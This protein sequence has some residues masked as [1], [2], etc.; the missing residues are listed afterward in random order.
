MDVVY[1]HCAGLDVH[2]QSVVACRIAR[3]TSGERVSEVCTFGTMTADILALSEWLSMAEVTHVAMESTGVYWK[4]IWN[5][6]EPSFK[7]VLVNPHHFKQV[8]GRKTDVKDAQWL[9]E[10]LE[11]GLLKPSF[12]PPAPQRALREMTRMRTTFIQQRADMVNRV[13]KVLEDANIKLASVATDVMGVSGRAMIEKMIGGE[14]DPKVLADLAA[15]RLRNKT[16]ALEKALFGRIQEHHRII[17]QQLMALIDSMDKSIAALDVEIE[18]RCAPFTAAVE[19][20]DTITGVG[21]STAQTILSEVGIDMSP[22]PTDGHLCAWSGV[23][24]GNNE[25]AGKRLSGKT[26]KGNRSLRVAL[27]Q[28]ANAAAR[29]KDTYLCALHRRIAS[30]RGKKRAIIAVAHA[31]LKIAY[32]MLKD[33]TDYIELGANYFDKLNSKR[34]PNRLIKRLEQMGYSVTKNPEILPVAA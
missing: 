10:L 8:P 12:I 1:P 4:P 17:L 20:L 26:R 13:Q 7:L 21:P 24:P 6:L 23:A 32:H 2:K 29:S 22:F 9:A 5:I 15:G 11:I 31:I 25:S 28:A 19:K 14:T 30:R 3:N 34:T 16:E 18:S 27:V 33:G